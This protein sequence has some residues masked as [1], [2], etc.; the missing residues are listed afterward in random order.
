MTGAR[1]RRVE[2]Q[3]RVTG[4]R[5]RVRASGRKQI[6]VTGARLRERVSGGKKL[7]ATGARFREPLGAARSSAV[8]QL[9]LVN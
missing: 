1:E 5:L 4:A 8:D 3:I 6:R 9:D 7:R 2:K